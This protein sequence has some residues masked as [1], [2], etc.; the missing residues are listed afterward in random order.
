MKKLLSTIFITLGVFYSSAQCTVTLNPSTIKVTQDSTIA[1]NLGANQY[2][3]VC[4]GVTLSY[5]GTQSAD[6]TYYLEDAAKVISLVSHEATLYMK[7]LSSIDANYSQ[8]GQWAITTN[9]WH[10]PSATF[11]DYIQG[12]N[13][14]ECTD[15]VFNYGSVGSCNATSGLEQEK[16]LF[17]FNSYP[18]PAKDQITI[19]TNSNTE[20]TISITTVLGQEVFKTSNNLKTTKVDL[21]SLKEGTYFITMQTSHG[22]KKMKKLIITK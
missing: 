5:D 17:T 2:Y 8:S 11:E 10:D 22:D 1:T 9:V 13:F 18:N 20:K 7:R 16:E 14:N 15:V 19:E 6:V 21:Q 4:A 3:L 12:S